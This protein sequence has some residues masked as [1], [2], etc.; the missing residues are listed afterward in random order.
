MADNTQGGNRR[1]N[2]STPI[3][4]SYGHLQ[5]QALDVERLVLGA[6]MRDKDAFTVVWELLHPESVYE[7]RDQKVYRAI[8]TLNMEEHP[9]DISTVIE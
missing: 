2:T 9:V 3:D 4:L 8:Q 5:P 7:P 6:W 1:K